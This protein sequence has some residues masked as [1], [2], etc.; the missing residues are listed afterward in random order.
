MNDG[1]KSLVS[2]GQNIRALR[3][4]Y[5][6][7]LRD[8]ARRLDI[9][10][11]AL[12][13]IETGVTDVNLSRLEQ[14]A[15]IFGVNLV[16]LWQID[17]EDAATKETNLNIARKKISELELEIAAFQRKVILLYEKLRQQSSTLQPAHA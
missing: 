5:G 7:S 6:W 15:Q 1:N 3:L 17:F 12:S 4:K 2:V 10:T 9:S 13:K 14:I 8:A 16:Q 11:S